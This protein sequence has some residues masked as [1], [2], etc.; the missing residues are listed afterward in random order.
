MSE[1]AQ[2]AAEAEADR[3]YAEILA[4][5]LRGKNV[6]AFLL[7]RAKHRRRAIERAMVHERRAHRAMLRLRA[8]LRKV[9]KGMYK[10]G[11]L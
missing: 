10:A 8:S 3:L 2:L 11:L 6:A 7:A 5:S 9:V 1:E 4:T